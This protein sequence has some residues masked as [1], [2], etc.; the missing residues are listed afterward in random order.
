MAGEWEYC[1]RMGNGAGSI[2]QNQELV[3]KR[4][5][6]AGAAKTNCNAKCEFQSQFLYLST[7]TREF[8]SSPICKAQK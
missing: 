5:T 4:S 2:L 7:P 8:L 3:L 6:V 1:R